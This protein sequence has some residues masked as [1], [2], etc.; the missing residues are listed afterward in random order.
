MSGIFTL[1]LIVNSESVK[2]YVKVNYQLLLANLFH[3]FPH[4]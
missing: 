1:S 2:S 4:F 3:L